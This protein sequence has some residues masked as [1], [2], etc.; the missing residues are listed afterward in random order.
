MENSKKKNLT[1]STCIT[2]ICLICLKHGKAE[3]IIIICWVYFIQN[4]CRVFQ[5]VTTMATFKIMNAEFI[6]VIMYTLWK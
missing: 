6:V 2:I 4:H 3:I 5:I 1:P